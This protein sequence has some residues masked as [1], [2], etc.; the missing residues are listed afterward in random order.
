MAVGIAAN[1]R[2]GTCQDNRGI[3]RAAQS[4]EP[5]YTQARC[6]C[7]I[8]VSH[9]KPKHHVALWQLSKCDW[10]GEGGVRRKQGT[11]VRDSVFAL[12]RIEGGQKSGKTEDEALP[13]LT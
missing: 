5:T 9:C 10:G 8:L 6:C 11:S 1:L 7:A 12:L 13:Q 2:S 3:P 4:Q